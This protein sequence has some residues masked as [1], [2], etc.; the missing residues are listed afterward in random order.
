[1]HAENTGEV[2]CPP[3][4]KHISA[5]MAGYGAAAQPEPG[6]TSNGGSGSSAIFVPMAGHGSVAQME[7]VP[8]NNRS[9]GSV[10][11]CFPH[12]RHLCVVYGTT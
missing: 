7:P 10:E 11:L 4:P 1:M 12:S 9:N 6:P 8:A 5:L 2:T 3:P